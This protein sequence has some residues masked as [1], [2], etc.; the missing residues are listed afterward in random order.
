[1]ELY[2][3]HNEPEQLIYYDIR[4]QIPKFAWRELRDT[5][6]EEDSDLEEVLATDAEYSYMYARD[7]LDDRFPAGEDAIATDAYNSYLYAQW[8]LGG[9]FELGEAEIMTD[10]ES[11]FL[12]ARDVIENRWL[13]A[14]D[15]IRQN[16]AWWGDYKREFGIK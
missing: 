5:D 11:A 1:M 7:V 3:L 4:L 12:Y 8:I 2:K 6:F 9:R 13:E 10:P 14:E 15:S 16:N